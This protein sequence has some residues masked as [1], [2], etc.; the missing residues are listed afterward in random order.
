M[1]QFRPVNQVREEF[2]SYFVERAR[3][4]FVP[5]SPVVPHDDPTLLFANAGMNQFKPLFLGNVAPG[6]PL[7]GLK[8]AV[9]SQKCIRAGGKHNDLDDVG[10]DGYHHTFFEMLGNWSFGDY[11]KAESVEWGWQLLTDV[12]GIDPA[13]LYASY[14]EG[15]REIGLEPDREAY[16][17]WRRYLP[18]ERIIPGNMKDNFWEMG[19]TGPCGPCSEIHYDGR[20]DAERARVP[21]SALVNKSD[22][23]VIE[24][25]NHVFI[26]FNR[27]AAGAEGLKPLPAKHVDTGMGLERIAR[28]I[29]GKS[30]N[31]DTDAFS[32]LFASIREICKAPA[33]AGSWTEPRDTAYR[34]IADHIRTLT[35]AITDGADPGNEGRNYVLRRILR[36][37]VRYGRQVLGV[38][39]PFLCELVPTVVETMGGAFPELN[40]NPRRVHDVIKDEEEAF[41]RTLAQGIVLFDRAASSGSV[42]AEDAFRL[43]DTYGFPID[44]TQLMA[45]E[46]GLKVD[47]EGFNRLMEEARIKAR[48]GGKATE[49][50]AGTMGTEALA[51]LRRMRIEPTD[52]SEKFSAKR[53]R[54]S[55][56]AIWNGHSFDEHVLARNTRPDDRFAVILD[57]TSFYAEMGGQQA[58]KGRMQVTRERRSS[59]SDSH[60]GGEFVVEEVRNIGGYVLHIGRVAK[61]ELRVGDDCELRVDLP[62]RKAVASNHT[63]THL[64]NWALREALGDHVDQKGSLVAADRLRFDF[65]HHQAMTIEQAH[66]VEQAVRKLIESNLPVFAEAVPL[67]AGKQIH[68]V[69]AVFGETYPDPVRLV[70]IGVKADE[71]RGD[72]GNARWRGYSAEFCGGT[73]LASTGEAEA[74]ALIAEEGVA[75]GVRRVTAFTGAQAVEAEALAAR[76]ASRISGAA[77]LDMKH[78]VP[79]VQAL[80]SEIDSA[81]VPLVRKNELRGMLSPLIERTRSAAKQAAGAD[82][83]KVVTA[84]RALAEHASGAAIVLELPAGADREALLAAMDTVR[85][86]HVQSAVMLIAAGADG[87]ATI[88]ASVPAALIEKGLKAGDWVREASAAVGGKGGGRPDSA[89]GGGPDGAKVALAVAAARSFAATKAG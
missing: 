50:G 72:P 60:E 20:R 40:K 9:N 33:Y 73:H 83:E 4:V 6:S 66:R 28:V 58:D 84:A 36:R 13:R 82:R 62:R 64:L 48:A 51:T 21:G 76:L 59:A 69:R 17:L 88:V 41:G 63:A 52:D 12:W 27:T 11:F 37:A 5:S 80:S 32:P 78:L 86:R 16:D 49:E 85:S 87:K 29:Q 67:A 19:D 18:A 81:V 55:V 56:M 74:F 79:E 57:R 24:I 44:L 70:S 2:I 7:A 25:W 45:E 39:G 42:A 10:K 61:G 38:S 22:P 46:R 1:P 26:Q 53:M 14:F 30:S 34:V 8:R 89:Q 3:H 47:V 65:S 54:A 71:M 77:T 15:N 31:Y 43:H 68:G 75:K 35:F 23:N